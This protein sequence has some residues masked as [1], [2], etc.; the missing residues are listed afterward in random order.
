MLPSAAK[1]ERFPLLHCTEC[2]FTAGLSNRT[3]VGKICTPADWKSAIRQIENLRYSAVDGRRL[4]ALRYSRLKI[5]ATK[6]RASSLQDSRIDRT[7]ERH[8]RLPIGNRR[9]SRLKICATP[10]RCMERGRR[11]A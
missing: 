4:E 5:C 7:S 9:Y 1:P 11:A 6:N 8:K 2:L 3:R 10:K